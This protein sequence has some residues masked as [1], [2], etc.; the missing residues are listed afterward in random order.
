MA[1]TKHFSFV[2]LRNLPTAP[3][4]TDIQYKVFNL[5]REKKQILE[6]AQKRNHSDTAESAISETIPNT[7]SAAC[8]SSFPPTAPERSSYLY[9][10]KKCRQML[11]VAVH[12]HVRVQTE[13]NPVDLQNS[14][15]VR[16]QRILSPGQYEQMAQTEQTAKNQVTLYCTFLKEVTT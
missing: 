3:A 6:V 15:S 10:R 13:D 12:V 11:F 14:S 2:S 7:I 1:A 5:P 16:R 4:D 9:W 8:A